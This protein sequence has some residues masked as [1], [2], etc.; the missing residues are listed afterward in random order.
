V[1]ASS[2]AAPNRGRTYSRNT[3]S[4]RVRVLGRR[5]SVVAHHSSYQARKRTRSCAGSTQALHHV[6]DV[7]FAEDT[8]RVRTGAG[9]TVMACLRNLAI[10]ALN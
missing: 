5:L 10:G 7:T 2:G 6:R 8:S 1:I 3:I 9:P 4:L